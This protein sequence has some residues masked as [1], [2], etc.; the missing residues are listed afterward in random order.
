MSKEMSEMS[1]IWVIPEAAPYLRRYFKQVQ[2]DC[3]NK[4]LQIEVQETNKLC[5]Y[6]WFTNLTLESTLTTCIFNQQ[7]EMPRLKFSGLRL[8]AHNCGWD[9]FDDSVDE[10]RSMTHFI[11]ISYDKME[12]GFEKEKTICVKSNEDQTLYDEEWCKTDHKMLVGG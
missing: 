7:V 1:D 9:L 6:K 12:I 2:W 10:S 3:V 5:A 11:T 4:L 8:T